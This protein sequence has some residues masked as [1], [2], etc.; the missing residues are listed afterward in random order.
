MTQDD[1]QLWTGETVS[2]TDAQWKRI[3]DVAKTRLASFLC[4]DRWPETMADDLEMLLANFICAVLRWQGT[5]EASVSSKS[6]RNFTISFENDGAVNAF[7]QV[8]KN[9]SDIIEKYSQCDTGMAVERSKIYNCAGK[10]QGGC[11]G[12]R[13]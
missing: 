1:Y 5:P 4:L 8:A 12:G 3:V 9:Y 13:L 11:C 10:A 7:A 2:Y 6:V